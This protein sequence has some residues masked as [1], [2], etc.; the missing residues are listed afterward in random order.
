MVVKL[1]YKKAKENGSIVDYKSYMEMY[2]ETGSR[3]SLVKG[4]PKIINI[5]GTYVE[6]VDLPLIV[7][8]IHM[9][10]IVQRF[11]YE[12]LPKIKFVWDRDKNGRV[13]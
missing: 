13:Q 11:T 8:D 3:F 5:E 2:D 6:L 1:S 9:K 12:F 10:Y 7:S 4:S